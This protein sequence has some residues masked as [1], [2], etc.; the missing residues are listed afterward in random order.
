[1]VAVMK[2]QKWRWLV[3]LSGFVVI[4]AAVS[5]MISYQTFIQ[6]E[7]QG[8]QDRANHYHSL[9]AGMLDQH[10]PL[11]SV[12]T[13]DPGVIGVLIKGQAIRSEEQSAI[14]TVC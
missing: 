10:K 6:T 5:Y 1:M 9:L 12:L 2:L 11:L 4:L 13:E 7:K 8:A 3:L 14:R